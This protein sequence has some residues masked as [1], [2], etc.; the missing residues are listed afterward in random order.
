MDLKSFTSYLNADST[1]E[2][3]HILLSL[4][5]S[6]ANLVVMHYKS[7]LQNEGLRSTTVN[8]RMSSLR[9]L[10]KEACKKGLV[11]WLL[12]ISNEKIVECPTRQLLT[13]VQV[14]QMFKACLGQNNGKKA[15]RDYAILRLVYDL[16]LKRSVITNLKVSDF[17]REFGTLTYQGEN[18]STAWTKKLS[19]AS[20]KALENWLQHRVSSG[21]LLFINLDN[22]SNIDG[23]SETSVYRIIKGI[24]ELCGIVINPDELRQSAIAHSLVK[25]KQF[26]MTEN[27]VLALSDHKHIKS[28]KRY[29][30]DHLKS[31]AKLTQLI[32]N[33]D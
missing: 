22:S 27:D 4:P 8:R 7:L 15:A 32:S 17:N 5:E 26:G 1:I 3:V 9:S 24:G 16:A 33:L 13:K 28:L 25:A 31:Q 14:T 10:V 20:Q 12:D 18:N 30:E 19:K 23:L 6:Q 11:N 2:A 21:V 29:Q